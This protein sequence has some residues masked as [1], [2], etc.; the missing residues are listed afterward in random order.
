MT[1]LFVPGLLH[2]HMS[3]QLFAP[4]LICIHMPRQLFAP[5]LICIH[6]PRQL[7]APD[8]ICIHMS[9]RD[10]RLVSV[11]GL[12]VFFLYCC[13]WIE[14]TKPYRSH[15]DNLIDPKVAVTKLHASGSQQ[16]RTTV[17]HE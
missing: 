16:N 17:Q 1:Q 11:P 4:D 15:Y 9:R 2:T 8:L 6:M 7:F 5:D 10:C 3:R 12:D 13:A 14:M